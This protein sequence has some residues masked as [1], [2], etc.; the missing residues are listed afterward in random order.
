MRYRAVEGHPAPP[1]AL[2]EGGRQRPEEAIA[3]PDTARS[4]QE[5]GDWRRETTARDTDRRA[6]RKQDSATGTGPG[7]PW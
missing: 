7:E 3:H 2:P 4:H 5:S 1:G 6:H